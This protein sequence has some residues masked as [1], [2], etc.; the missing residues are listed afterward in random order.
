MALEIGV[1]NAGVRML[2]VMALIPFLFVEV[3]IHFSWL[4]VFPMA[5]NLMSLTG[6]I[7]AAWGGALERKLGY[8]IRWGIAH[9]LPFILIPVSI[10][11]FF[12]RPDILLSVLFLAWVLAHLAQ[13]F[14]ESIKHTM[15]SHSV[16][17]E[18]LGRLFGF[19]NVAMAVFGV[20]AS[21]VIWFV[22]QR[23]D[24]QDNYI[25]LSWIGV[26]CI[27]GSL[28]IFG[29]IKET[30]M[31]PVEPK[32][33]R[34]R[35]DVWRD[36]YATWKSDPRIHW[37]VY[38][39]WA[40]CTGMFINTYAIVVFMQ[41]CDLTTEDMWL[42]VLLITLS[43]ILSFGFTGWLV[44][45]W[46][47]RQS[48]IGSGVVMAFNAFL[49]M[50]LETIWGFALLFPLLTLAQGM[51]RNAWPTMV[52]KMTTVEKRPQYHA[53]INLAVLPGMYTA[54]ISGILLVRFTEFD[55]VFY[56]TLVGS[57][58]GSLCFMIGLPKAAAEDAENTS[59]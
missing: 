15:M 11:F 53:T 43:E 12:D 30:P 51:M 38:G 44:D 40:R 26:A 55:I 19:R 18:W 13:G 17:E 41:R 21:G 35:M 50:Q 14:S 5:R 56:C 32:P 42:P 1:Y 10:L 48:M 47:A 58:L 27:L 45:K 6:P 2:G 29:Q 4:G 33:K 23:Y 28:L 20:M 31:D 52:L 54:F 34:R 59:A 49:I 8:C 46:G 16:N 25:V 36:A 22:G 57:L 9:R 39:R 3:G 7:G 37:M 24:G